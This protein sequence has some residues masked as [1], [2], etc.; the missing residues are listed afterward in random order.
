MVILKF[1]LIS[2]GRYKIALNMLLSLQNSLIKEIDN[3]TLNQGE[4]FTRIPVM[5]GNT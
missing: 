5:C 3:A 1:V 2:L 4:D